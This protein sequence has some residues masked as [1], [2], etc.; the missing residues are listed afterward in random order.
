MSERVTVRVSAATLATAK[1]YAE[2]KD[3]EIGDAIDGLVATAD[4]RRKALAK[5][6]KDGAGKPRRK[7]FKPT[8]GLGKKKKPKVRRG[9]RA[10]APLAESAGANEVPGAE[11]SAPETQRSE[12]APARS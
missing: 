6:A 8:G 12:R 7:A 3:I 4:S 11:E 1:R 2:A 5:Y 9:K 10:S